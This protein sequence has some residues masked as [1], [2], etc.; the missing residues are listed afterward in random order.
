MANKSGRIGS[1]WESRLLGWFRGRPKWRAE[2][3]HLAGVNDEGDLVVYDPWGDDPWIVEAKA[4]R[5]MNLSAYVR[6][7]EVEAAN[8]ARARGM[9]RVPNW[10]VVVKR[11]NQPINKAYVV[12]T[13][14][15]F[16]RQIEDA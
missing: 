4:E 9:R 1:E 16:A 11:R 12:C 13:L 2:R 14:E 15:E 6:E 5:Q 7:A 10:I 8:Y 3:L